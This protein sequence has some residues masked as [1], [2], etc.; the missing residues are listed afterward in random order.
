MSRGEGGRQALRYE[1]RFCHLCFPHGQEDPGRGWY[2][3]HF[4]TLGQ[5]LFPCETQC[6]DQVR[7]RFG[8]TEHRTVWRCH[9][10]HLDG[11]PPV[12]GRSCG[13]GFGRGQHHRACG[14]TGSHRASHTHYPQSGHSLQPSGERWRGTLQAEGY[15]AGTDNGK[16]KG[17]NGKR[18]RHTEKPGCR[19]TGC[20]CRGD[21]GLRPLSVRYHTCSARGSVWRTDTERPPGRPEHG[22]CRYGSFAYRDR[23][24][25]GDKVPGHLRQRGD[26]KPDKAGC[27]FSLLCFAG[28]ETC[29]TTGRG[30]WFRGL[31]HVHREVVHGECRQCSCM[32]SQL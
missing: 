6:R 2:A 9:N 13:A 1:E 16:R 12:V 7:G 27:R 24:S 25:R 32:A 26:W 20:G 30:R 17:E 3:H 29:G 4:G 10:V 5:S 23:Y 22:A 8:Q 14:A 15:V 18:L 11:P 28:A 21:S 19:G 31:C